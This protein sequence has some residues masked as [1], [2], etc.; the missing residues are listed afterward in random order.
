MVIH[1]ALKPKDDTY[2]SKKKKGGGRGLT[3]I[4]DCMAISIPGLE[5]IKKRRERL[6]TRNT[7]DNIMINRK[8]KTRK[9]ESIEK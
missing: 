3:S 8:T 1:S 7:T 5:D 2:V 4:E 9:Q 6:I